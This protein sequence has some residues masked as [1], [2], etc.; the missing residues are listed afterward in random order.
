MKNIIY[1][2]FAL[3][4]LSGCYTTQYV[5]K[6]KLDIASV[7]KNG[8]KSKDTIKSNYFEDSLIQIVWS[9]TEKKLDFELLNKSDKNFQ[10]LWDE[11][12]MVIDGKS[13]RIFHYGV[14]LV[15]AE[16]SQ[17]PTTVIHGAT[18]SDAILPA[19]NVDYTPATTGGYGVTIPGHW[20]TK[21][22]YIIATGGT[23]DEAVEKATPQIGKNIIVSIPIKQGDQKFEYVFTF[24][25]KDIVVKEEEKFDA[26]KSSRA[27]LAGVLIGT[28]GATVMLTKLFSSFP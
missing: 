19:D 3:I 16:K 10:V 9:P 13:M 25:I 23:M 28:L 17:P 1:S 24:V 22:I 14:K 2:L 8:T 26:K 27:A 6:Y 7:D 18:L 4:T 5:G 11:A 12:A 21:N 20:D 15:E